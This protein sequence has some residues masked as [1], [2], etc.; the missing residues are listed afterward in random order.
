MLIIMAIVH[1][2]K[3]VI[4]SNIKRVNLPFK[5]QLPQYNV[6]ETLNIN[7]GKYLTQILKQISNSQYKTPLTKATNS[8]IWINQ[9]IKLGWT[10]LSCDLYI[11]TE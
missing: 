8:Q 7:T 6:A 10:T 5:K 11:T 9:H 2:P 3:H 4:L 1:S